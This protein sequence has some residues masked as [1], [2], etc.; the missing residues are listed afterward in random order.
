MCYVELKLSRLSRHL[1]DGTTV[2][3]VRQGVAV[4][5]S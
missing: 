1:I 4:V 3:E 2:V 5:T